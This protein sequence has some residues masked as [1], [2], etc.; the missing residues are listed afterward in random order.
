MI[1]QSEKAKSSQLNYL[2]DPVM[3]GTMTIYVKT[4]KQLISNSHQQELHSGGGTT[5]TFLHKKF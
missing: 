4:V 3:S 1:F 2:K 5:C